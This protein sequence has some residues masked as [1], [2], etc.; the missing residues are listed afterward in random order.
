MSALPPNQAAAASVSQTVIDCPE[1]WGDEVVG[2]D[3]DSTGGFHKIH[4][5]RRCLQADG[6]PFFVG[7][8]E[9]GGIYPP[10]MASSEFSGAAKIFLTKDDYNTAIS[11]QDYLTD[12][13][14]TDCL[15]EDY[16]TLDLLISTCSFAYS[17]YNKL[18]EHLS[19]IFTM[20]YFGKAPITLN[21]SGNL[22]EYPGQNAKAHL[23]ELYSKLF[24]ITKVAQHK[25]VPNI[26][27]VGFVAQGAILSLTLSESSAVQD[28][29]AFNMQFLVFNLYARNYNS[30]GRVSTVDIIYNERSRMAPSDIKKTGN[31]DGIN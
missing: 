8:E 10:T 22:M 24:R 3:E 20:H 14:V 28:A 18:D 6:K 21:V 26:Q 31:W 13:L 29:I 12:S 23:M 25:I 2:V 5:D 27:F 7:N 30:T 19:D 9:I 15:R 11:M 16:I 4:I 17:D 1:S